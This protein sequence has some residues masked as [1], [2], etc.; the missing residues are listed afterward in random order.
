AS[1]RRA[2]VRGTLTAGRTG[3]NVGPAERGDPM[4]VPIAHDD[5]DDGARAPGTARPGGSR[6]WRRRPAGDAAREPAPAWTIVV[7]LGILIV[8]G[9]VGWRA[10]H[11]PRPPEPFPLRVVDEAGRPVEGA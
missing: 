3:P 11:A 6:S 7:G 5:A 10:G 1:V 4:D 9:I 2:S 8:A